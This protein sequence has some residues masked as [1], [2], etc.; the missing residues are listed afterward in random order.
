M[1]RTV[2]DTAALLQAIAGY[3]GYDDRQLEAPR[4]QDVPKYVDE[5]LA[6]R[7]QGI[8][9]MKIAVLKEALELP[10]LAPQVKQLLLDAIDR[11]KK[12]GAE[13]FEVSIP[14]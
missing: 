13:V 12:L 9:G 1:A 6:A 5:L 10:A 2:L 4:P 14:L 3:D 8:Q 7:P 11:L